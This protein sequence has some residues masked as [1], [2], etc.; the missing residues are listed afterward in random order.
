MHTFIFDAHDDHP[1]AECELVD[2]GIGVAN[3]AAAPLDN[4]RPISSF[5]RTATGTVIGGAVG[6]RW[7]QCCELQQLWVEPAMRCK[8]I[9]AEL[10][11]VFESRA[12]AHGCNAIYLETFSFQSPQLYFALGY[13]VDCERRGYPDGISKYHMSKCIGRQ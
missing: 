1:A 2:R 11:R 5:A 3:D 13:G 8:G 9:G 10:V 12:V 6:R 7:G 4:V